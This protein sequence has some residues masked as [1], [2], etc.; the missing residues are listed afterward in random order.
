M[1]VQELTQNQLLAAA[2]ACPRERTFCSYISALMTF[3]N[4]QLVLNVNEV[5]RRTHPKEYR[6]MKACRK[7]STD[8]RR[9]QRL[10]LQTKEAW[11]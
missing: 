9:R 4:Y 5:G 7:Q 1:E 3:D 11:Q 10:C 6:S 2:I 8:R